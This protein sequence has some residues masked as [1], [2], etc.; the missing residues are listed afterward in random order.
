[1]A[2]RRAGSESNSSMTLAIGFLGARSDQR[3][4]LVA[5]SALMT[6]TGLA[7]AWS[8]AYATVLVV[9]VAGTLNP[10]AGSISVFVPLEHAVLSRAVADAERGLT[11]VDDAILIAIHQRCQEHAADDAEDSGIGADAE[12][13]SDDDRESQA[14]CSPQ[15][16]PCDPHLL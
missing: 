16:A 2:T 1:M 9:A 6:A 7:L 12:R 10:S 13:E 14:F 8:S 5:A 15:R 4:L 3:R 11:D